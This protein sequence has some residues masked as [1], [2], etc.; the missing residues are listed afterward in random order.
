MSVRKW[1]KIQEVLLKVRT[2]GSG[3]SP[4]VSPNPKRKQWDQVSQFPPTVW[5]MGGLTPGP[6][7]R[8]LLMLLQ[9][10]ETLLK[11]IGE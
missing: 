5:E 11:K 6:D 7:P 10:L 9:E 3:L 1:E 8:T 2:R 4:C